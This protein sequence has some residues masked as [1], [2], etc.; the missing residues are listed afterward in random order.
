VDKAFHPALYDYLLGLIEA[1]GKVDLLVRI[2][3][4]KALEGL[5]V[6]WDFS[7]SA[8]LPVLQR[9]ISALFVISFECETGSAR[10]SFLETLS[11]VVDRVGDAI[12]PFLGDLLNPIDKLWSAADGPMWSLWKMS[13]LSLLQKVIDVVSHG[14]TVSPLI[15][16][17]NL[18]E[19]AKVLIP[20]IA[21]CSDRQSP[22]FI[23]LHEPA[24]QLWEEIVTSSAQY[25]EELHSLL[26][27]LP[28]VLQNCDAE[29]FPVLVDIIEAHVIRAPQRVIQDYGQTVLV[30]YF[31]RF[32]LQQSI[33]EKNEGRVCRTLELVLQLQSDNILGVFGHILVALKTHVLSARSS[34]ESGKLNTTYLT[35]IARTFL[36]Y[37]DAARRA[38]VS[39]KEEM[40]QLIDV[41]ISL[42]QS[43]GNSPLAV[44]RRK[45]WV[46]VL[47][48]QVIDV[49][50]TFPEDLAARLASV[51]N[52]WAEVR[53][54]LATDSQ[55]KIARDQLS[56]AL[57]LDKNDVVAQLKK[58]VLA[59]DPVFSL[60][61]VRM[62]KE[63]LE[64]AQSRSR[65]DL[66][67]SIIAQD[68]SLEAL[69][70]GPLLN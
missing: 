4:V 5:V 45:L 34:G 25:T 58:E 2:S 20:L 41:W 16:D 3:A 36:V 11:Q 32:L 67:R 18:S 48:R 23:H 17:T 62:L 15:R 30:P 51:A 43:L 6:S 59:R 26:Q 27:R 31:E 68:A 8:F 54:E 14:E 9:C 42:F 28:D 13:V 22:D 46:I 38:I 65:P 35:V 55:V 40:L 12:I 19:L 39:S 21:S 7:A 70:N 49:L 56:K 47:C 1:S 10:K 29:M 64:T 66:V 37:G 57:K 61:L 44:W 33:T 24:T 52:L 63:T 60:D 69:L 53:T 50:V